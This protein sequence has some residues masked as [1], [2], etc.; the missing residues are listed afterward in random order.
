LSLRT[1]VAHSPRPASCL[2]WF[3]RRYLPLKTPLLS[4]DQGVTPIPSSLT[5]PTTVPS[6]SA[7]QQ[8]SRPGLKWRRNFAVISQTNA[9][10]S[11]FQP[12]SS[13]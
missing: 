7:T 10:Y 13:A 12:Y 11:S 5:D 2:P 4:G 6:R 3:S 1:L 8:R 9:S